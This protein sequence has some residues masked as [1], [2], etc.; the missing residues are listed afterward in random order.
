LPLVQVV[1]LTLDDSIEEALA[2]R[3]APPDLQKTPGGAPT[4][5]APLPEVV[6]S[7]KYV[8]LTQV[9]ILFTHVG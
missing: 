1:W 5:A 6:R 9:S 8:A 7:L 2:R 4:P 3:L